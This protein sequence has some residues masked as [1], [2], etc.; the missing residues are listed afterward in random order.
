MMQSGVLF[1]GDAYASDV[2]IRN[3]KNKIICNIGAKNE[4]YIYCVLCVNNEN[5]TFL[6]IWKVKGQL[7]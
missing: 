3:G 5:D 7:T 6:F 4:T 2:E 1:T